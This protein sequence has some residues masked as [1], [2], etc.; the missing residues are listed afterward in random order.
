VSLHPVVLTATAILVVDGI[1]AIKGH[2]LIAVIG[3]ERP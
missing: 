3:L 1:V 2:H